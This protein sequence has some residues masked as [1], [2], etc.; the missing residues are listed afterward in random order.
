M[1]VNNVFQVNFRTKSVSFSFSFARVF[2]ERCQIGEKSNSILTISATSTD[3]NDYNDDGLVPR[4]YAIVG[5][6]FMRS[7]ISFDLFG[8]DF[9]HEDGQYFDRLICFEFEEL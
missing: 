8:G 9:T 1:S 4:G 7:S 6:D 2:P 3:S 5:D